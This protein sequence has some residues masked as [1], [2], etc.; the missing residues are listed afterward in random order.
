MEGTI[1][2]NHNDNTRQVEEEE[3][4]KFLYSLLEQMFENTDVVDKIKEI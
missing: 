1:L 2:L 4:S 3:K